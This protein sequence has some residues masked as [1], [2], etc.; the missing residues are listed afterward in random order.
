MMAIAMADVL[1]PEPMTLEQ[2]ADMDDDEPGEL[3]D[4]VLVEEEVPTNLHELI[5]SWVSY[6]LMTW[7]KERGGRV[8]GS[9]HKLG[10]SARRGRK[11]DV[12]VYAPRTKMSWQASLSRIPPLIVVEVISRR[13]RDVRRDRAEKLGDYARFGVRWYWL[14]DPE[15]R[16]IEVL[17][18]GA[19]G[20]YT[21]A[22]QA[23]T[24]RV[25][26]P[27][28]EPLELEL[29]DLWKTVDEAMAEGDEEEEESGEG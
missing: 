21:I 20:R 14:V 26:V 4:G 6:A 22:M 25:A 27:G 19:D 29:A 18:L 10:V 3:V 8:F 15:A 23:S 17:E 2:W 12:T 11:P 24:E 16:L 1:Q 9:D 13:A 7:A 28:C 5:V